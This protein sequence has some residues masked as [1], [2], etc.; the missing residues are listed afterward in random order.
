[1]HLAT[2]GKFFGGEGPYDIMILQ[3]F[4]ACFIN[5]VQPLV[6]KLVFFSK[7]GN[8]LATRDTDLAGHID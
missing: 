8:F 4:C 6:P 1:M 2:S 7:L 5:H 3:R